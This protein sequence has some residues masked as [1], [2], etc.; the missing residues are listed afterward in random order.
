MR[1]FAVAVLTSLIA[2]PA[3]HAA[4]EA[5]PSPTAEVEEGFVPLFDGKTLEGWIG[6]VKGYT[7]ENGILFCDPKK[8]GGH[9]FT[10]NDYANFIYRFDFRLPPGGNNGIAVRAPASGNPAY[11]SMELQVLDDTHP[12]YAKLKDYQF[13]GSVYGV[14]PAKRGALKPVGEW[15]EQEIKA[16]GT[17]L[18]ITLNGTVIVDV[19][20]AKVEPID[21]HK[22]PG[23]LREKGHLGFC[24]HGDKV[25]FRN[26]RIKELE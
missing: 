25:E 17:K 11:T 13:H 16:D 12:K 1:V 10:K 20:L 9:L 6:A 8:G 4:D 24:G 7:A 14:V 5:T 2:I 23:L 26:L 18:T 19:D 21:G 3:A 22:H 15:N